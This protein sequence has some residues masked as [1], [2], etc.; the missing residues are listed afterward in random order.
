MAISKEEVIQKIEAALE[1]IR[2]QDVD[3]FLLTWHI[4][5]HMPLSGIAPDDTM[6]IRCS[7]P[8][9]A[10]PNLLRRM[11]DGTGKAKPWEKL[12]KEKEEQEVE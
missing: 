2:Q 1:E 3:H 4:V 12:A 10:L 5:D 8:L 9:E 11:G 7:M 6:P